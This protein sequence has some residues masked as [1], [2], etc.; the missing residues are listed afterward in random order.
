MP[1]L[2]VIDDEPAILEMIKGHFLI[3]GYE[4]LTAGD[5]AEGLEILEA[6]HPDVVVLDLKMKKVDGDQFLKQ[7]REKNI[8]AR[9]LVVTGYQDEELRIKIEKLGVDAFLEKPASILEIQRKIE[10]LTRVNR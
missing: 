5:G 6:A 2:L 8:G 7:M 4:V 1:K 3:R 9:V 10:E